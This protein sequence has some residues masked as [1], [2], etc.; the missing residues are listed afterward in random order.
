MAENASSLIEDTAG[1]REIAGIDLLRFAAA[2]M[3]MAFH[4]GFWGCAAPHSRTNSLV[5]VHACFPGLAPFTSTGW[6]GVEIFFAISGFVISWSAQGQSA[7]SFVRRRFLRLAPAAWICAT[8]TACVA[9]AFAHAEPG[10]LTRAYLRTLVFFPTAPWVDDAY[11]T[12]GVEIAF[13][14]VIAVVLAC[15]C[16]HRL[17]LVVAAIGG[18]SASFWI[19]RAVA[20]A[21][22][23]SSLSSVLDAVA[24]SR[25]SEL[26]LVQHGCFFCLGAILC[27]AVGGRLPRRAL[28]ALALTSCV[29]G[30][31]EIAASAARKAAITGYSLSVAAPIAIWAIGML[32]IAGSIR[33]ATQPQ[34]SPFL[35][36]A[37]RMGSAWARRVGSA[38]PRRV[39]LMTYPLYL[40]HTLVGSVAIAAL[41]RGGASGAL[42]LAL[43]MSLSVA[44]AFIVSDTLEPALR[45][46]LA[47]CVSGGTAGAPAAAPAIAIVLPEAAAAAGPTP[48]ALYGEV[49]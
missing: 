29:G 23:P 36:W 22:G 19:L 27:D 47:Y 11:W 20:G 37:R 10:E 21:S 45:R 6:V 38:W 4:L 44:L 28:F 34:R 5:G 13:Y 18:A 39:G 49:A 8:I 2:F 30:G 40:I 26:A 1:R 3:V 42:A 33:L 17:P 48:A 15:G 32:V 9:L 7:L 43:A 46:A 16:S 31:L 41:I 25:Y 35:A 12:L 14:A 24:G